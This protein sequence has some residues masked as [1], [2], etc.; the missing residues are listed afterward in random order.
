MAQTKLPLNHYRECGVYMIKNIITGDSYIGSSNNIGKRWSLH[1]CKLSQNKHYNKHFQSSVNK[2]G[3]E[4]FIF[5]VIEF[6]KEPELISKEQDNYNKYSPTYNKGIFID[7]PQ[8][9]SKMSEEQKEKFRI[10]NTGRIKTESEKDL[11]RIAN[12][13]KSC[14]HYNWEK[15]G[16]TRWKPVI[17]YDGITNY[18]FKNAVTAAKYF[19]VTKTSIIRCCKT[20]NELLTTIKLK[21]ASH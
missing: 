16:I 6:C 21:Y 18:Y 9:G 15:A 8:R 10:A 1:Y 5:G 7:C 2:Y 11:L 3:I 13:G 17:A 4:N 19:N 14:K 20:G 12:L